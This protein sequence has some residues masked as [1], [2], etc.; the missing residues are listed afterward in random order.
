[1]RIQNSNVAVPLRSIVLVAFFIIISITFAQS[2]TN[3]QFQIACSGPAN[4]AWDYSAKENG[5]CTCPDSIPLPA[6]DFGYPIDVCQNGNGLTGSFSAQGLST[7]LKGSVSGQ[8]VNFTLTSKFTMN[9]NGIKINETLTDTNRGTLNGNSISG[10]VSSNWKFNVSGQG[11]NVS[12]GCNLNGTFKVQLSGGGPGP[13]PDPGDDNPVTED[14]TGISGLID[15]VVET[16]GVQWTDI[17]KDGK[18][19]LFMVGDNVS[20]IFK[21]N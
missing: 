10:S 6:F 21:N 18:Q 14:V 3:F 2:E 15:Q 9:S 16:V 8:Q 7:K 12:C 5:S 19:D 4:G 20:S 13:G 1:M 11:V 17:N